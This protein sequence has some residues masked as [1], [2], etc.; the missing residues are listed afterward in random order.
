MTKLKTRLPIKALS[1]LMAVLMIFST[2]SIMFTVSAALSD[3]EGRGNGTWYEINTALSLYSEYLNDDGTI[4]YSGQA[5]SDNSLYGTHTVHYSIYMPEGYA[6]NYAEYKASGKKLATMLVLSGG[7]DVLN[8]GADTYS[9]MA[10]VTGLN[11]LADEQGIVLI[12]LKM[13]DD[14]LNPSYYWNFFLDSFQTRSSGTSSSSQRPLGQICDMVDDVKDR[15]NTAFGDIITDDGKDRTYVAGFSAGSCLAANMI[16]VYP[17]KFEGA[18]LVAGMPYGMFRTWD[19]GYSYGGYANAMYGGTDGDLNEWSKTYS[20]GWVSITYSWDRQATSTYANKVTSA[21]STAGISSAST[22][23]DAPRVI[24]LHGENDNVVNIVNGEQTASAFAIAYGASTTGSSYNQRAVY[25]L[26]ETKT[27]YTASYYGLNSS[28]LGDVNTSVGYSKARSSRFAFMVFDGNAHTWISDNSQSVMSNADNSASGVSSAMGGTSDYY[29]Y[30]DII[31]DFFE[32]EPSYYEADDVEPDGEAIYASYGARFCA[33]EGVKFADVVTAQG[34]QLTNLPISP[35]YL[36]ADTDS[37][38]ATEWNFNFD[39]TSKISVESAKITDPRYKLTIESIKVYQNVWVSAD[40]TTINMGYDVIDSAAISQGGSNAVALDGVTKIASWTGTPKF[41][42]NQFVTEIPVSEELSDELIEKGVLSIVNYGSSADYNV[43]SPVIVVTYGQTLANPEEAVPGDGVTK[44]SAKIFPVFAYNSAAGYNAPDSAANET[45]TYSGIEGHLIGTAK[46]Y[47]VGVYNAGDANDKIYYSFNL[48]DY[49][50]LN[51]NS[52]QSITIDFAIEGNPYYSKEDVGVK[53]MAIGNMHWDNVSDLPSDYITLSEKYTLAKGERIEGQI[54]IDQPS[55]LNRVNNLGG[56]TLV[57][58]NT[59][60]NEHYYF[61]STM[62]TITVNYEHVPGTSVNEL[63][64]IGTRTELGYDDLVSDDNL[65]EKGEATVGG[66]VS[67][68]PTLEKGNYSTDTSGDQVAS[69]TNTTTSTSPQNN[70]SNAFS[71][72]DIYNT[73]YSQILSDVQSMYTDMTYE[74]DYWIVISEIKLTSAKMSI[75]A[76]RENRSYSGTVYGYYSPSAQSS[77]TAGFTGESNYQV[78]SGSLSNS[79]TNEMTFTSD[80]FSPN[81]VFTEES[82]YFWLKS[83][84]DPSYSNT[85][86]QALVGIPTLSDVEI[87]YVATVTMTEPEVDDGG[88]NE[89]TLPT[90]DPNDGYVKVELGDDAKG[91]ADAPITLTP[92]SGRFVTSASNTE[93]SS[94]STWRDISTWTTS[95][96][97]LYGLILNYDIYSYYSQLEAYTEALAKYESMYP[98]SQGYKVSGSL[99]NTLTLTGTSAGQYERTFYAIAGN[100]EYNVYNSSMKQGV[101]FT[102]DASTSYTATLTDFPEITESNPILTIYYG[103]LTSGTYYRISNIPTASYNYNYEII[104]YQLADPILSATATT[105]AADRTVTFNVVT[106]GPF[107]SIRIAGVDYTDSYV[108]ADGNRE[109][110]VTIAAPESNTTYTVSAAKTGVIDSRTATVTVTGVGAPDEP[111]EED[112]IKD[113]TGNTLTGIVNGSAYKVPDEYY[114]ETRTVTS[115]SAKPVT[116]TIFPVSGYLVG[117][118]SNY[119]TNSSSDYFTGPQ[120]DTGSPQANVALDTSKTSFPVS[121]LGYAYMNYDVSSYFAL[122]EPKTLVSDNTANPDVTT[123]EAGVTTSVITK[124]YQETVVSGI[125]VNTIKAQEGYTGGWASRYTVSGSTGVMGGAEWTGTDKPED[126]YQ[127]LG[128]GDVTS[129]M[130]NIGT[131]ANINSVHLAAARENGYV[132]VWVNNTGSDWSSRFYPSAWLLVDMP[133]VTVT[134]KTITYTEK[135][136]TETKKVTQATQSESTEKVN[137]TTSSSVTTAENGYLYGYST[138]YYSTNSSYY[139]TST[140]SSTKSYQAQAQVNMSSSSLNNGNFA[141]TYLGSGYA[142]YDVSSLIALNGLSSETTTDEITTAVINGKETEVRKEVINYTQREITSITVSGTVQAGFT[143]N[144]SA[145]NSYNVTN[146]FYIGSF[147]DWSGNSY[148]AKSEA[149]WALIETIDNIRI[150]SQSLNATISQEENGEVYAAILENGRLTIRVDNTYNDWNN[151][152]KDCA[153]TLVS[154]P[155]ITVNYKTT[156]WTE[157]KLTQTQATDTFSPEYEVYAQ[158]RFTGANGESYSKTKYLGEMTGYGAQGVVTPYVVAAGATHGT[159]NALFTSPVAEGAKPTNSVLIT[160]KESDTANYKLKRAYIEQTGQEVAVL[161]DKGDG[162]YLLDTTLTSDMIKTNDTYKIR[163]IFEYESEAETPIP[164]SEIVKVNLHSVFENYDANGNKLE[165]VGQ[166]DSLVFAKLTDLSYILSLDDADIPFGDYNVNGVNGTDVS[167][168]A[169][170]NRIYTLDIDKTQVKLGSLGTQKTDTNEFATT[171]YQAKAYLDV[172]GDTPARGDILVVTYNGG[173]TTGD[174]DVYLYYRATKQYDV[175]VNYEFDIVDENGNSV[176]T[177]KYTYNKDFQLSVGDVIFPYDALSTE[178]EDFT[179]VSL[180]LKGESEAKSYKVGQFDWTITTTNGITYDEDTLMI[181]DISADGEITFK[182]EM[183][184]K[185]NTNVT[186]NH[187]YNVNYGGNVYTAALHATSGVITAP[188]GGSIAVVLDDT[189]VAFTID[190]KE[191]FFTASQF[192]PVRVETDTDG[193]EFGTYAFD[194]VFTATKVPYNTDNATVTIVYEINVNKVVVIEKFAQNGVIADDQKTTTVYVPSNT[195]YTFT[196]SFTPSQQPFSDGVTLNQYTATSSD[197]TLDSDK[198]G[199]TSFSIVSLNADKTVTIV[200]D[201]ATYAQ[202]PLNVIH[203]FYKNGVL[204]GTKTESG[205]TTLTNDPNGIGSYTV[206]PFSGTVDGISGSISSAIVDASNYYANGMTSGNSNVSLSGYVVTYIN[207][208]ATGPQDGIDVIV[209]YDITDTASVTV[210]HKFYINGTE[211]TANVTNTPTASLTLTKGVSQSITAAQ[212]TVEY[213]GTTFSLSDFAKTASTVSAGFETDGLNVTLNA[214][215]A[216]DG[217]VTVRYDL[218]VREITVTEIFKDS[219]STLGTETTVLYVADGKSYTFTSE[220]NSYNGIE[221]TNFSREISDGYTLGTGIPA[222]FT[223][224]ASADADVTITYTVGTQAN[225][226]VNHEYYINGQPVS[227]VL[228]NEPTSSLVLNKGVSQAITLAQGTVNFNGTIFNVSDF[229]PIISSTDGI[230]VDGINATLTEFNVTTGEITVQYSLIVYTVNV[231]EIFTKD[232]VTVE[233]VTTTAYVKAGDTYTFASDYATGDIISDVALGDYVRTAQGADVTTAGNGAATFTVSDVAATTNVTINYAVSTKTTANV[234]YVYIVN[235]APVSVDTI[236]DGAST[237]V[238]VNGQAIAAPS[239]TGYYTLTG[240]T[241]SIDDFT[242]TVTVTAG[243]ATVVNNEVILNAYNVADNTV[244]VTVTY[245]ITISKE[246]PATVYHTYY[247]NGVEITGDALANVTA[248]TP[249]LNLV[250][251]E[252]QTINKSTG[253]VNYNGTEF[254]LSQFD[255][256][257]TYSDALSMNGFEVTLIK[258]NVGAQNI[259]VRYDLT[260]YTVVVNEVFYVNGVQA[261]TVTNTY[262]VSAKDAALTAG[263]VNGSATVNGIAVSNFITSVTDNSDVIDGAITAGNYVATVNGS[264]IVTVEYNISTKTN[265]NITSIFKVNGSTDGIDTTYVTNATATQNGFEYGVSTPV[266]SLAGGYVIWNGTQLNVSDFTASITNYDV[267]TIAASGLN[268]TVNKYNTDATDIVITY[269][270]NVVSV[271]LTENFFVDGETVETQVTTKWYP[272]NSEYTFVSDYGN[273]YVPAGTSIA[274]SNYTVYGGVKNSDGFVEFTGTATD[275]AAFAVDY[276]VTT[277]AIA[278]VTHKY[279]FNGEEITPVITTEGSDIINLTFGVSTPIALTEG[280]HVFNGKTFNLSDADVTVTSSNANVVVEGTNVVLNAYNQTATDITVRYD[281]STV[282]VNVTET[283]VT[284]EGHTVN[285]GTQTIYLLEGEAFEFVSA[286]SPTDTIVVNGVTIPYSLFTK[287]VTGADGF[288]VDTSSNVTISGTMEGKRADIEIVYGGVKTTAVVKLYQRFYYKNSESA[289]GTL[290]NNHNYVTIPGFA[291]SVGDRIALSD[292][293]DDLTFT[294]NGVTLTV[295]TTFFQWQDLEANGIDGY[296]EDNYFVI[297]YIA[298]NTAAETTVDLNYN[299]NLFSDVNVV[300]EFYVNGKLADEAT[301]TETITSVR[302]VSATSSSYNSNFKIA[303]KTSGTITVGGTKYNISE[304]TV[305]D[306]LIETTGL[307]IKRS[308]V[309]NQTNKF[310]VQSYDFSTDERTVVIRYDILTTLEEAEVTVNSNYVNNGEFVGELSGSVVT[311]LK[312][313]D[314]IA[315]ETVK[316]INGIEVTFAVQSV[317]ANGITI[318]EENGVYTV[319]EIAPDATEWSIDITYVAAATANVK[320]THNFY[321][322]GK[323]LGTITDNTVIVNLANHSGKFVALNGIVGVTTDKGIVFVDA[324]RF[325]VTLA[326]GAD[327]GTFAN[328]IYTLNASALNGST[329]EITFDYNID[330]ISFALDGE[331]GVKQTASATDVDGQYKVVTTVN[332]VGN[333]KPID[334]IFV[335]DVSAGMGDASNAQLDNAKAEISEYITNSFAVNN[336]V[337]VAIV[338]YADGYEVLTGGYITDK[339]TA[340]ATVEAIALAEAKDGY[341]VT[342]SNLQAGLYG[343]RMLMNADVRRAYTDVIVIKGSEPNAAYSK[344]NDASYNYSAKIDATAD[345]ANA[346]A[347][348]ELDKMNASNEI[349]IDLTNAETNVDATMTE[350]FDARNYINVNGEAYI[351]INADEFT[352]VAANGVTVNGEA[353]EYTYREKDGLI[354]IK[355]LGTLKGEITIEYTLELTDK[356][357]GD[358]FVSDE[359][360]IAYLDTVDDAREVIYGTSARVSYSTTVTGA[361][362]TVITYLANSD[363]NP[364]GMD[365]LTVKNFYEDAIIGKPVVYAVSGITNLTAGTTYDVKAPV[366]SGYTLWDNEQSTKT[367]VIPEEGENAVVYFGYYASGALVDDSVVYDDTSA[368]VFDVLSNDTRP[369]GES[370]D[371]I[372]G[373]GATESEALGG[374]RDKVSTTYGDLIIIDGGKVRYAP[375]GINV[376]GEFYYAVQDGDGIYVGKIYV[377]PA[378]IVKADITSSVQVQIGDRWTIVHESSNNDEKLEVSADKEITDYNPKTNGGLPTNK[379]NESGN[380]VAGMDYTFSVDPAEAGD[381]SWYY[382]NGDLTDGVKGGTANDEYLGWF[383]QK[384]DVVFDLGITHKITSVEVT[385]LTYEPNAIRTPSFTLSVSDDGVNYTVYKVYN[386]ANE[387]NNYRTARELELE[388]DSAVAGRYVKITTT[389]TAAGWVF[390]G[391]IEIYGSMDLALDSDYTIET[392]GDIF[393]S[394]SIFEDKDMDR[395]TNGNK[396]TGDIDNN[397]EVNSTQVDYTGDYIIWNNV[398][399]INVIVDLGAVMKTGTYSVHSAGDFWGTA[400]I[401]NVEVYVSTDGVNYEPVYGQ[402]HTQEFIKNGETTQDATANVSKVYTDYVSSGKLVS[403]RY[404]MFKITPDKSFT[405]FAAIDE[406]EVSGELMDYYEPTYE[407]LLSGKTYESS[408][409]SDVVSGDGNYAA[410]LTDGIA[411]KTDSGEYWFGLRSDLVASGTQANVVNDKAEMVFDLGDVYD[412]LSARIHFRNVY[413]SSVVAPESVKLW[414][415]VDGENYNKYVTF[416]VDTVEDD[417]YWSIIRNIGGLVGRY[418]KIEIELNSDKQN[419]GGGWVFLNEIE[420]YGNEV[421]DDYFVSD[422]ASNDANDIYGGYEDD[423]KN[424]FQFDGNDA[425][426]A[427]R[428]QDYVANGNVDGTDS[429]YTATFSFTGTGFD[430]ISVTGL[431]NGYMTIKTWDSAGNLVSN[432]SGSISTFALTENIYQATVFTCTDLAYDTYTVE[433]I[434][435]RTYL[436][437]IGMTDTQVYVD[438]VRTYNPFANNTNEHY[439]DLQ[440]GTVTETLKSIFVDGNLA[441]STGGNGLFTQSGMLDINSYMDNGT[442][443]AINIIGGQSLLFKLDEASAN[444]TFQIEMAAVGNSATVEVYVNSKLAETLTID[445]GVFAYY[446]FSRYIREDSTVNFE[447]KSGQVTFTK[448]RYKDAVLGEPVGEKYTTDDIAT[449]YSPDGE[450]LSKDYTVNTARLVK[451]SGTSRTITALVYTSVNAD[452]VII[453]TSGYRIAPATVTKKTNST[454]TQNYF[455]LTYTLPDD[456][457]AGEVVID[458]YAYD[459]A[460]NAYSSSPK[461]TTYT[462]N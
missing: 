19:D 422:K 226:T 151:S 394:N 204:V 83:Y 325:T 209:R 64:G 72:Y 273:S 353:V 164:E 225:V 251:G 46:K 97:T 150:A 438:S 189:K 11:C 80:A 198:G 45:K 153:W 423:Y 345:E 118:N 409:G 310:A 236:I 246:A 69:G 331:V 405:G 286:H 157:T 174:I 374:N 193:I 361:T 14:G 177:Q 99:T 290:V 272:I 313:G 88:S 380:L 352:F 140:T 136:I 188:S 395:L 311:N 247:I 344:Y 135:T 266:T 421:S 274:L 354:S 32:G 100:T 194:G 181:T 326:N 308:T 152:Y 186:V 185:T 229:T 358:Y 258:Y 228:S 12:Y 300:H 138:S 330:G 261:D 292:E 98:E 283:V 125:R 81:I 113:A 2:I 146:E 167:A 254:N 316:T 224:T 285:V 404:V 302:I 101:Q 348:Y 364:V 375:N 338:T 142:E 411:Y 371:F 366:V 417:C 18:A 263:L 390:L 385:Y 249:S 87:T 276:K 89:P 212:G 208:D 275:N 270:I 434:A 155:D 356:V 341:D 448:L 67:I 250:Y 362:I 413:T 137:T 335:V 107:D 66:T 182:Y 110:T 287:T 414:V 49:T 281:L 47:S 429:Q 235:G 378:T 10:Q 309:T 221:I 108:N 314:V 131:A 267:E 294:V 295:N 388:I 3:E 343:A 412:L 387:A 451:Y 367:V 143:G 441:V 392:D 202:A 26:T 171:D 265:V 22:N 269:T 1:V 33:P 447:V 418:V 377:V 383:G 304:F 393:E 179:S 178:A 426:Y 239:A 4:A 328:D 332:S 291:L 419:G 452:S 35:E 93:S 416:A 241:Y 389:P 456:V 119:Y 17:D 63:E 109:Y 245:E 446:D 455:V 244:K 260:V 40:G 58:E 73:A 396:N 240:S 207:A 15:L 264:G 359:I 379:A 255:T 165:T 357:E 147:A 211:V 408:T 391:E 349:V 450:L 433:V 376:T 256:T 112:V 59:A 124:V 415:S 420:V 82:P 176:A 156:T 31:W 163:I 436:P 203:Q 324:N 44:T 342:A 384:N 280:T 74:Q 458:F 116:K 449:G 192:T 215:N 169:G 121:Y 5:T 407:N 403:A 217:A 428:Y 27:G 149:G 71:S 134:Y 398:S 317:V 53:V 363:L 76:K 95:Y 184:V 288:T 148:P 191:V 234:E 297:D 351:T 51:N 336:N 445:T 197:V 90:Y 346:A 104:V 293:N 130:G 158:Y 68:T 8:A 329:Y 381:G 141:V 222:T 365:G 233:T 243:D 214:F 91:G 34:L 36:H 315:N 139:R 172:T 117:T 144:N 406:V 282:V 435:L 86:R 57:F 307:T 431:K 257:V 129:T 284:T 289:Q 223:A 37:S 7:S 213:N 368:I 253:T 242:K 20:A 437:R 52:I 162:T 298:P 340:L 123:D 460:N 442:N 259:T 168:I 319:T 16:S 41:Q 173:D 180:T 43:A 231:T 216:A 159:V 457:P 440:N 175:T 333:T 312:I 444:A 120:R 369:T 320:L 200:Y 60:S 218:T 166:I 42:D 62:P 382:V 271:T 196:S 301:I 268:V 453:Y 29:D 279:F 454:G 439:N 39:L 303:Q 133:T 339:D 13:T 154:L 56:F 248:G 323:L 105:N 318:T 145:A 432:A 230:A 430:I 28:L 360:K 337:R 96:S 350:I 79:N 54:I 397:G 183:V 206:V 161:Q 24:V 132:T 402:Y 355:N 78:I 65:Y 400:S 296:I 399:Y 25:D 48:K 401:E 232:A 187:Q 462:L 106:T 252:S 425:L 199:Y 75:L 220:F 461:N 94:T 210:E 92:S 21:W 372:Y 115:T 9:A 373:I 347:N 127:I 237:M 386:L 322:A 334:L 219:T 38:T 370:F 238:L 126:R 227:A 84:G 327:Y 305:D 111:V 443:N 70:S 306:S 50:K 278:S 424:N 61:L 23:A 321:V 77:D 299:I 55:I 103:Y 277:K 128:S 427:N 410:N 201:Y 160:E 85:D 459:S 114:D 170:S 30:N 205:V 102:S 190:D 262:Y 122:E 195:A 6:D